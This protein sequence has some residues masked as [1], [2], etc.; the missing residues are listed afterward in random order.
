M[1]LKVPN[2]VS[3]KRKSLLVTLTLIRNISYFG[4]FPSAV[5][6]PSPLCKQK[7]TKLWRNG[8]EDTQESWVGN[9]T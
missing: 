6:V 9:A 2:S 7:S 5:S 4:E 1:Q 8:D 3:W